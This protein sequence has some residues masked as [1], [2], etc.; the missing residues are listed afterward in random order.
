MAYNDRHG[1]DQR[2]SETPRISELGLPT[3]R[4]SHDLLGEPGEVDANRKQDPPGG[5]FC[6][7]FGLCGLVPQQFLFTLNALPNAAYR[8]I[9]KIQTDQCCGCRNK[10]ER[11]GGRPLITHLDLDQCIWR[12]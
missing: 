8:G 11:T 7:A 12:I 1:L 10:C 6:P 5:N 3:F 2:T 4:L 9:L